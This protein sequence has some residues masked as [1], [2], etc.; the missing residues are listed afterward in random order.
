MTR[1]STV[2]PN[3]ED[4][5][6]RFLESLPS[7]GAAVRL[8]STIIQSRRVGCL[9]FNRDSHR[10]CVTSIQTTFVMYS[11]VCIV[12]VVVACTLSVA[13]G[14]VDV[15]ITRLSHNFAVNTTIGNTTY[16]QIVSA[17]IC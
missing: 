5:E 17:S 8:L 9:K 1:M 16:S 6:E 13:A 15:P 14:I 10:F 11:R 3:T 2:T 7:T 12:L 4:K